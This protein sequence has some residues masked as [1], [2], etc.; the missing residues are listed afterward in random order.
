MK[1]SIFTLALALGMT[2]AFAQET[3]TGLVSKKGEPYLPETGDWGI[4]VDASPFLGYIG[5]FFSNAGATS[6][7]N[8]FSTPYTITGKYFTSEKMAYRAKLRLGWTSSKTTTETL[9]LTSTAT[10]TPMVEDEV[11]VSDRNITLGGGL[12]W[13]RGKTRLQGLYGAE[14]LINMM[15]GK[16]T[17]TYGNAI[18]STNSG[19]RP[20]E[21]KMSGTFGFSVRGFVGAEYFILPKM[22]LGLEYGWAIGISKGGY[23][24]STTEF[25]NGTAVETT[26]GNTG[27]KAGSFGIDNDNSGG[28]ITLGF[29]F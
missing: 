1:K 14:A 11:K 4:V 3:N 26:T 28:M 15:G 13:R 29:H 24:E 2:G 18:T 19:P 12:E 23:G 10:P 22:S 17:Y 7:S 27:S 21:S 6:P 20:T 9:D 25:W 16:T 5:G 8:T